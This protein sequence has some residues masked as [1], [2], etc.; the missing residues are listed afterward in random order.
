M[1]LPCEGDSDHHTKTVIAGK[2]VVEVHLTGGT[3]TPHRRGVTRDVGQEYILCL[4]RV[5]E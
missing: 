4:V 5:E 1:L 3:D 2:A